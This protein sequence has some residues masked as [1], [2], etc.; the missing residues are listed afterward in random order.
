[1][2]N[3]DKKG[4]KKEDK[5]QAD[6]KRFQI[7]T[8]TKILCLNQHCTNLVPEDCCCNLKRV[9]IGPGGKCAGFLKTTVKKKTTAKKKKTGK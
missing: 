2:S 5:I 8:D 9:V 4:I 1:M 6:I 7:E 3:E